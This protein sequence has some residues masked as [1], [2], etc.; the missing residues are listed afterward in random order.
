[1]KSFMSYTEGQHPCMPPACTNVGIVYKHMACMWTNP[2]HRH[3]IILSSTY[4]MCA[5]GMHTTKFEVLSS[6]M[7]EENGV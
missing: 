1:M 3:P 2:P 7:S 4:L 6:C 5:H